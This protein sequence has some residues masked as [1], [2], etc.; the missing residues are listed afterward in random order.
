MARFASGGRN[1]TT[2]QCYAPT[3]LAGVED[4]E[5]VYEQSQGRHLKGSERKRINSG[6]P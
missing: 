3:N 5:E 4:K 2:I 1:I 6:A